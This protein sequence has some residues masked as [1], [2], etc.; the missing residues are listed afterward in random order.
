MHFIFYEL[1]GKGDWERLAAQK[2]HHYAKGM[3]HI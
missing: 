1:Y 3:V 2:I